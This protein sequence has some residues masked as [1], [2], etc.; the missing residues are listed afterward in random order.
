MTTV[1]PVSSLV[2]VVILAVWAV[3][4]VQH[5]VRRRDH[6][7]TARSVDRFSEAMRVLE[8]R[9]SLPVPEAATHPRSYAASPLR[10]ARPGRPQVVVKGPHPVS[11]ATAVAP[12]RDHRR[13][14]SAARLR[15]GALLTGWLSMVVL[16]GLAI[17][18]VTERWTAMVGVV[19]CGLSVALV[20]WS[21]ARERAA[22]RAPAAR[23][24][25]PAR[26]ATAP[27]RVPVP[28]RAP[29]TRPAPT[30]RPVAAEGE[31]PVAASG[32]GHEFSAQS[33]AATL[34][35]GVRHEPARTVAPA[36]QSGPELYDLHAVEA[37]LAEVP[38]GAPQA[39]P[40]PAAEPEAAS[41]PA[42]LEGATVADGTWAPVPVP[43]P[44]YT[45]KAK[46]Y[47]PLPSAP[48]SL[49][50][51]GTEMALEE[52]FEDLPRVDRVG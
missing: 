10:P 43:P 12:S 50:A 46:A 7:A 14:R 28:R 36:A 15:A 33:V 13:H 29:A 52:E 11:G 34:R 45:L 1:P 44:T 17:A 5:W 22:R 3:Y 30:A 40:A 35:T 27:R 42:G 25:A 39:R 47:R 24:A 6:L 38:V 16:V 48:S 26:R 32:G 20:R 9:R 49:P 4:L 51:D 21:V 37:S 41:A 19:A 8:R 2:F 18:G 23:R 31:I